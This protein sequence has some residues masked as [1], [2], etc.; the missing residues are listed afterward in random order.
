MTESYH[1]DKRARALVAA[2][3]G[4]DDDELLTSKECAH[5]LGCSTAWLQGGRSKGFGP[6]YVGLGRSIK[7]RRRDVLAWLDQRRVHAEQL[8][9]SKGK[10]KR[11]PS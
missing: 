6:P 7:Y 4:G 9:Q 10:K 8:A 3:I 2:S 1:L 5:W 11:R